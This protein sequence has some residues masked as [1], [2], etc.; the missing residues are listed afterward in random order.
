MCDVLTGRHSS[1]VH[2][3]VHMNLREHNGVFTVTTNAS[4]SYIQKKM[5]LIS[6]QL[7]QIF[8]ISG[9]HLIAFDVYSFKGALCNVC[10]S[11]NSDFL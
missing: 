1:K 9:S 3:D 10:K 4:F 6:I 11:S 5:F 7:W 8:V 2:T